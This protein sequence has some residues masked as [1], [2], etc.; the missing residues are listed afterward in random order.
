MSQYFCMLW[1]VPIKSVNPLLSF[2]RL[3]STLPQAATTSYNISNVNELLPFLTGVGQPFL[4]FLPPL[5]V[6]QRY[7][8]FFNLPNLFLFFCS[9]DRNRTCKSLRII[10]QLL[11]HHGASTIPPPDY[12]FISSNILSNSSPYSFDFSNRSSDCLINS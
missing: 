5:F 10:A 2:V 11:Y 6:L 4:T 9:Q 12:F 7:V 8:K 3:T 1:R